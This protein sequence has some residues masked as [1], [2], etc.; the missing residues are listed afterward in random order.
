MANTTQTALEIAAY[1]Q[2]EL[3]LRIPTLACVQYF[4]SDTNPYLILGTG[5][6]GTPGAV[7][8]V[9]PQPRLGVDCLGLASVEFSPHMCL[10][11]TEA[12]ATGPADPTPAATKAQIWLTV[13]SFGTRVDIYESTTGNFP[14]VADFAS[15]TNFKTT[16]QNLKYPL[17]NSI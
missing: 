1:L 8:K 15:T 5:V 13:A 17:I 10:V 14:A 16:F 2:K 3:P 4:D 11:E 6:A 9:M 7:I 12:V